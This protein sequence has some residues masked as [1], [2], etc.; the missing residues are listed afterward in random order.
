MLFA[1]LGG[2]PCILSRRKARVFPKSG[3]KVIGCVETEKKRSFGNRMVLLQQQFCLLYFQII[4]KGSGSAACL[5][6]KFGFEMRERKG[7]ACGSVLQRYFFKKMIMDIGDG[8]GDAFR[9]G[10]LQTAGKLKNPVEAAD[11][12]LP[13]QCLGQRIARGKKA[14]CFGQIRFQHSAAPEKAGQIPEFFAQKIRLYFVEPKNGTGG[15]Q[16]ELKPDDMADALRKITGTMGFVRISD[17]YVIS[18]QAEQIAVHLI[19]LKPAYE[20]YHFQTTG[21]DMGAKGQSRAVGGMDSKNGESGEHT[22]FRS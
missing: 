10:K 14:E 5:L 1:R 16:I 15:R 18:G 22:L 6:L 8:V 4:D 2:L 17:E 7:A 11:E 9:L 20:K 3:R 21:M 13:P 19:N 12:Q